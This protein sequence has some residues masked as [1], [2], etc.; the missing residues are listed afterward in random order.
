VS[1]AATYI[2]IRAASM[3]VAVNL[4]VTSLFGRT[5][6]MLETT[7]LTDDEVARIERAVEKVFNVDAAD[8]RALC[9]TVRAL[10]GDLDTA[11]ARVA[12]FNDL[13]QTCAEQLAA[14]TQERDHWRDRCL[15]AN[16][17]LNDSQSTTN[18]VEEG[19]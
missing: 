12:K 15:R 17:D 9:Q 7:I 16:A 11:L 10:R 1:I 19:N 4:H 14:V 13:N 6:I 2:T 5:V 3:V 18:E 8:I